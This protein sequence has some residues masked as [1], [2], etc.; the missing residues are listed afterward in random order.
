MLKPFL[1]LVVIFAASF[2]ISSLSMSTKEEEVEANNPTVRVIKSDSDPREYRYF[3]LDNGLQVL[4]ISDPA[5]DRAA[6]SMDVSVG[7]FSDP[8]DFPGLAHFLEHML[9]MGST[10]YPDENQYSAFLSQHG[11][12]SNAYTGPENTNY[13]FDIVPKNFHEALDIFA[14]FFV[15][16][17]IKETSTEREVMAV[18]NEHMK[19][20]QS[21]GWRG[22]MLVKTMANKAHPQH[23]FGTGN[24]N[25]LCNSS[26]TGTKE[27]H[28]HKTREAL[29]A[30]WTEHY[31]APRMRLVL[32]STDDLGS[33]EALARKSFSAVPAKGNPSPPQWKAPLKPPGAGAR[34]IKFVPIR[35]T[36]ELSLS[37][38][39][40]PLYTNF[41]NKA[42]SYLTH[43]IGHEATGS[44]AAKLKKAGLIESLSASADSSQRYASAIEISVSL[45]PAGLQNVDQVLAAVFQFIK[46]LKDKG[47]QHWVWKECA[48]IA[49]MHFRF[50]EKSDPAGYVVG[51]AASLQLYPPEYVIS[52]GYTYDKWDPQFITWVLEKLDPKDV[53]IYTAAKAYESEA[54]LTEPIYGTKYSLTEIDAKTLRKW[55]SGPIDTDLHMVKPNKFIPRNFSL[56]KPTVDVKKETKDSPPVKL[57]DR[58]GARLWYKQDVDFRGK[59][60]KP[61]PKLTI[62]FQIVTP[63]AE[64]TPRA[65][66]LSTL[67]A[68]LYS[69]A[70]VETTYDATT[71]GSSWSLAPSGDSFAL[72]VSGYSDQLG[73]LLKQVVEP[74][75]TCLKQKQKCMW[76]DPQRFEVMKDEMKRGFENSKKSSPHQRAAKRLGEIV[77][78]KSWSTDRLLYEL[79]LSDVTL[80]AV[81]AHVTQL[82][83]RV[84]IEGFVHGNTSP[85]EAKK[86]LDIVT[87]ALSPVALPENERELQEV[88][89]LENGLIF[90]EAHTNPEDTNHAIELYYQSPTYGMKTDLLAALFGQMASEPAFD[91]LRT[92]EQLGYIVALRP[93]SMGGTFPPNIPGMAVLIQSSVKDP[94]GLELSARHF[95]DGFVANLTNGYDAK[96]FESF[97]TSVLDS[98]LEKETSVGEQTIRFWGEIKKKRYDWTRRDKLVETLKPITL[99]EVTEYAKELTKLQSHSLAV[100]IYGKGMEPPTELDAIEGA[101]GRTRIH[102]VTTFKK[103]PPVYWPNEIPKAQ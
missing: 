103:T 15:A 33:L 62:L 39:L 68:M 12:S 5:S 9:F 65:A 91:Q 7:H 30:L 78:K 3:E 42:T 37:F 34:M 44:I 28:C 16:P 64:V 67:F 17:L 19:N 74:V 13:H 23:K 77:A 98:I 35:D 94:E 86:F 36:R 95:V 14:Q 51:L 88:L 4:A 87:V 82:F 46:L 41:K 81:A 47:P 49:G 48:D 27:T 58:Q 75:V 85:D 55:A 32:L 2:S 69:D 50:K 31:T 92:K 89:K 90:A 66:I 26:R 63:Y 70:M 102:S 100:W 101:R 99:K 56:A 10:K 29:M 1:V 38:N 20:L 40:P 59:N 57:V 18:Q 25:T 45:T 8:E 73:R 43:L 11:G 71:A 72:T 54:K 6:A 96:V 97:K 79:S 52:H 83:E 21:D 84:F 80:D 22:Q 24:L 60:W 53:D 61:K 76:A 93:K